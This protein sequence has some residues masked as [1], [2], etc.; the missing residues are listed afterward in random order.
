M[1]YSGVNN[2]SVMLHAYILL[3]LPQRL[4]EIDQNSQAIMTSVSLRVDPDEGA[5]SG[6]HGN[7]AVVF[8]STNLP[9]V[10]LK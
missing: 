2:Y 7:T 4:S 5:E 3:S 8:D 6:S 10:K 9:S 1:M